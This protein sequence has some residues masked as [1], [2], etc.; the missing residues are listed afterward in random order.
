[1]CFHA[2]QLQNSSDEIKIPGY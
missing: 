2:F 1:M